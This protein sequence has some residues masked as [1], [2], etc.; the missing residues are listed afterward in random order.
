MLPMDQE[1][2]NLA[3]MKSVCQRSQRDHWRNS[4]KALA[5]NG[6]ARPVWLIWFVLFIWSIWFIWFISF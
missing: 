2:H 6:L 3:L 1:V 5:V 4:R